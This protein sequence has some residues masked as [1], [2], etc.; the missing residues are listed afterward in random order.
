MEIL[1]DVCVAPLDRNYKQSWK[2]ATL[3]VNNYHIF[4]TS[5]HI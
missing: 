4:F 1:Q 2:P 3:E 5:T